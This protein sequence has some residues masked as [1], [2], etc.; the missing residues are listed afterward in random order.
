MGTFTGFF[1]LEN[2]QECKENDLIVAKKERKKRVS[3]NE[4][5]A[6]AIMY[7]IHTDQVFFSL[8]FQKSLGFSGQQQLNNYYLSIE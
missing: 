5:H 8:T 4:Q 2:Q 7:K 6:I 1:K 3:R